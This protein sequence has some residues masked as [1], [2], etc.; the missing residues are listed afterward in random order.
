[1]SDNIVFLLKKDA[2]KAGLTSPV[3]RC[4]PVHRAEIDLRPVLDDLLRSNIPSAIVLERLGQCAVWRKPMK[5]RLRPSWDFA[6]EGNG[7]APVIGK[8]RN[9]QSNF[10]HA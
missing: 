1:M 4:V 9:A 8:R 5:K 10:N 3:T 2:K 6:D 7:P